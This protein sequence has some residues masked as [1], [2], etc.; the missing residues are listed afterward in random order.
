MWEP[1]PAKG[2]EGAAVRIRPFDYVTDTGA[3]LSFMPELYE[4]NFPGCVVD[5]EFM[6]RRRSQLRAAVRDPSQKVLVAEDSLGVC[7]FIWLVMEQEFSRRRRGEVSAI[8][9]H[10]RARGRGVGR[11][12]MEAGEEHLRS[13]GCQSVMLMV[14]ATNQAALSLY[15]SLG[16]E[17]TRYQMEKPLPRKS[18]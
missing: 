3:L 7:G 4:T 14:T 10:P 15:R 11:Q 12:L 18:R 6:A 1:N 16:Y 9:V 2:S 8:Y 13:C 17:T 5:V